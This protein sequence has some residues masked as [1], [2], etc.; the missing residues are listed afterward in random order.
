M[1]ATTIAQDTRG[2]AAMARQNIYLAD[3]HGLVTE[4][5]EHS[6]EEEDVAREVLLYAKDM[7]NMQN[8]Q[9]VRSLRAS[10][11]LP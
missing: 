9:Q 11:D 10:L 3:A 4:T 6:S 1:L 7:D 2:M 8:L 5:S